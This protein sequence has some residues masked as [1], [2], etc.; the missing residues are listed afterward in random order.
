MPELT[1]TYQIPEDGDCKKCKHCL[2][3]TFALKDG[4]SNSLCIVFMRYGVIDRK[5]CNECKDFLA[6]EASKAIV[7][8]EEYTYNCTSKELK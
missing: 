6:E 2:R 4:T 7:L 1:V 3:N 8:P 5:G